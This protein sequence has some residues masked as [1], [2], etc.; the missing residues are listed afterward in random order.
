MDEVKKIDEIDVKIIR[1]LQANARS[2]VSEIAEKIK[3]SVPAVSER[4]KKLENSGIISKYTCVLDNAKLGRE[5]T[6]FLFVSL[7]TPDCMDQLREAIAGE[8]DVLESHYITGT[9]D[10]ILKVVTTDTDSLER[11]IYRIKRIPGVQKSN[12]CVVLSTDKDLLP[13]QL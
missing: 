1:L 2:T 8:K 10:Y 7:D 11:L 12:T 9:F 6:A 4:I 13:I 5:L 3:M